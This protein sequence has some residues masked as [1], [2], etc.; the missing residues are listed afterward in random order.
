MWNMQVRNTSRN[1]IKKLPVWYKV[2]VIAEAYEEMK[3]SFEK[4]GE[5]NILIRDRIT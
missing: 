5:V 2:D 1:I 4:Y 3:F